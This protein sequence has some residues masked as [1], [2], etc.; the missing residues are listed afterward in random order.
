MPRPK[1]ISDSLVLDA[2]H[3]LIHEHGPDGLTFGRLA[4]A[5]GLA[6]STLVQRFATKADLIQRTLVYAWDALASRTARLGAEAPKT[7]E[8]AIQILVALSGDYG[9]IESYADGLLVLRED[10]RAPVLRARGAAWNAALSSLLDDC[11]AATPDA[12]RDIGRLLA[13][14]WQGAVLWWSFDPREDVSTFVERSLRRF[15]AAAL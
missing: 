15:L 5:C 12:P 13:A 10:I 4:A 14:Q 1:T 2:A 6:T 7:P 11:F 3:R 8:G 9:G